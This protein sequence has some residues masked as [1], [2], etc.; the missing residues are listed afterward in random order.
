MPSAEKMSDAEDA[1]VPASRRKIPFVPLLLILLLLAF[2]VFGQRGILRALQLGR[3]KAALEVQV[4][5]LEETNAALRQEIEALRSDPRTIEAI[6]RR[7]LGMVKEDELSYQFRRAPEK[8]EPPGA[9]Q[10]LP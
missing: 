2:A 6:A 5:E 3:Q 7:E 8:K 10:D 4:K 1:K 9:A